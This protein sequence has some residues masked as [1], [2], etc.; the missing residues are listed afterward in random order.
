MNEKIKLSIVLIA[1]LTSVGMFANNEDVSKFINSGDID[2]IEAAAPQKNDMLNLYSK[3]KSNHGSDFKFHYSQNGKDVFEILVGNEKY[4]IISNT[5]D[6]QVL[7]VKEINNL[8]CNMAGDMKNSCIEKNGTADSPSDSINENTPKTKKENKELSP[9]VQQIV[10]AMHAGLTP[11]EQLQIKQA[12]EQYTKILNQK[13][14]SGYDPKAKQYINISNNS[15]PPKINIAKGYN[16]NISFVSPSGEYYDVVSAISS[17]KA[18]VSPVSPN[19]KDKKNILLVVGKANASTS[20]RFYLLGKDSPY[21]IFIST[22][23]TLTSDDSTD[24]SFKVG[25]SSSIGGYSTGGVDNSSLGYNNALLNALDYSPGNAWQKIPTENNDSSINFSLFRNDGLTIARVDGGEVIS[26]SYEE[27]AKREGV[28]AYE[29]NSQP[30]FFIVSSSN[31]SVYT[32]TAKDAEKTLSTSQ[33]RVVFKQQRRTKYKMNLN[34]VR[35][36]PNQVLSRRA[37]LSLYNSDPISAPKYAS[38]EFSFSEKIQNKP[39]ILSL[40]LTKGENIESAVN[41]LVGKAGISKL[42]WNSKKDYVADNSYV[43]SGTDLSGLLSNLL[44]GSG[45]KAK[46]YKN[47]ILVVSDDE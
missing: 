9:K 35:V 29:Y 47:G 26:P 30:N 37:T 40:S 4:R 3:I 38:G 45:M 24:I 5:K 10:K 7:Q 28:N 39:K 41:D 8:N 6:K 33:S 15:Q 34:S 18:V 42:I 23:G 32:Y 13:I 16:A 44:D 21:T 46:I 11:E 19:N 31:G 20:I 43:V 14:Q 27:S 17:D 12:D 25:D 22:D 36:D 2:Y 1:S